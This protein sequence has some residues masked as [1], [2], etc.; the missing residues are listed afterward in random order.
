M[1]ALSLIDCAAEECYVELTDNSILLHSVQQAG[2]ELLNVQSEAGTI[3]HL[4]QEFDQHVGRHRQAIITLENLPSAVA[5]LQMGRNTGLCIR[6][7]VI[8]C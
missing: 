4:S 8:L 3:F 1:I 6:W 7:Q 2:S 5:L